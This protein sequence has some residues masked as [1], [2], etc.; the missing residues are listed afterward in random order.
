MDIFVY[1][2]STYY[3]IDANYQFTTRSMI[4]LYFALITEVVTEMQPA[5]CAHDRPVFPISIGSLLEGT[6]D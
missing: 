6:L 5:H 2:H 1:M 4:S 3:D